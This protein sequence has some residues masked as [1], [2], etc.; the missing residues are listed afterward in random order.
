M[1]NSLCILL[2]LTNSLFSQNLIPNSGFEDIVECPNAYPGNT[3]I[4]LATPWTVIRENSTTDLWNDC[5]FEPGNDPWGDLDFYEN[6]YL[7]NPPHNGTSRARIRTYSK[8]TP[9]IREFIQIPLSEPLIVGQTYKLQFYAKVLTASS[10]AHDFFGALFTVGKLN[11]IDLYPYSNQSPPTENYNEIINHQVQV[12]TNG[13]FESQDDYGFVEGIFTAQ[14]AYT[15]MSM[16]VF[17]SHETIK[18][19]TL[20]DIGNS[21]TDLVLDDITLELTSSY[22]D[23]EEES[24]DKNKLWK[25][26]TD[27]HHLYIEAEKDA[28]KIIIYDIMGRK[29]YSQS[30]KIPKSETSNLTLP[31]LTTGSYVYQILN[32][33]QS[34]H[35]GRL[36]IE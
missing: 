2:L 21:F 18:T 13:I 15:H 22:V 6:R 30:Q 19:T 25:V 14:E 17:V 20:N 34:I 3:Q 10:I 27:K 4:E 16:G 24:N 7:E 26:Y 9:N 35:Q 28:S 12:K 11:Y 31:I 1:K 33:K 8:N 23:I 36:Y 32:N 29:I 5:V